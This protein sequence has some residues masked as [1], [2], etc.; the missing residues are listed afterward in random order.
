MS[1]A[2]AFGLGLASKNSISL[3][4]FADSLVVIGAK[5]VILQLYIR[6]LMGQ[7]GNP[8]F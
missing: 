2:A 7:S 3:P 6:L 4:L 8:L 1:Q 5:L